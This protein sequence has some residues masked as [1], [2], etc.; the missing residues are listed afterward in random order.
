MA[1][2]TF[3]M[4]KY[5]PV[6][7]SLDIDFKAPAR[8]D[9]TAEARLDADTIAAATAEADDSGRGRYELHA[10]VTDAEGTVVATT[11]GQYQIR[12]AKP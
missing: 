8:S 5:R 4:A 7:K 10:T 1:A 9:V 11:V 6:V 3:D 2:V 12:T